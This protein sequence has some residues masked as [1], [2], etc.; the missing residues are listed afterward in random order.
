MAGIRKQI[1]FDLDTKALEKYYPSDSWQNAYDIIKRHMEKMDL[2]G[3]R[4]LYMF[5][6]MSCQQEK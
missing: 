4:D 6:K 3:C 2:P 1:A 5:Q